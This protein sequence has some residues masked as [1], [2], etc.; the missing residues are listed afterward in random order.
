[1]TNAPCAVWAIR[2]SSVNAS[3]HRIELHP[4]YILHSKPY[5]DT[6]LL[7]EAFSQYYGR[8]GL[9]ARGVRGGKGKKRSPLQSFRR[10]LMSWHGRGD[11][12]TL[13]QWE[14]DGAPLMLSGKAVLSG[15]YLNELL[16]R[17]TH[18]HDPHPEL[19]ELYAEVLYCLA[20]RPDAQ[21]TCLRH[22]EL[23]L[24]E[25]LGYGLILD[26]QAD[27]GEVIEPDAEY[28]YYLERGPL[29]EASS[30]AGIPLHGQ[31]LLEL[32]ARA[33]SDARAHREAKQLMRAVLQRYLGD[34]P[35][36]SREVFRQSL[37]L[38]KGP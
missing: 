27:S 14:T 29:R 9:V 30:C 2:I 18:R 19:F 5:R 24:V 32:S 17:L 7:I 12:A 31:T 1:M 38:N 3:S 16:L 26:H 13:G 11:L 34:R 25:S 22:F 23:D 10:Y 20:N 6:S 37:Q 8:I 33:L 4:V 21:E 15:F 35:L 28:C 36:Q